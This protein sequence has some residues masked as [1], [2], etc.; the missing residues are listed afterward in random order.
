MSLQKQKGTINTIFTNLAKPIDTNILN[1][2]SIKKNETQPYQKPII[3]SVVADNNQ[4]IA[5]SDE[6]IEN[7]LKDFDFNITYG[8][9]LGN[10]SYT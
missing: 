2:K 10:I 4:I 8:P 7:K 9:S 3:K 6:E 5:L 1:A